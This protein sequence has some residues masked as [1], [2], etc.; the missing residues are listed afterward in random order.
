MMQMLRPKM[1]AVMM[2]KRSRFF[3]MMPEPAAALYIEE[4]I[5]SETPVPLPECMRMSRMVRIPEMN[6][7]ARRKT[8]RGPTEKL[9]V[10]RRCRYKG[11]E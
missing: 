8:L 10:L 4:A 6:M 1:T 11:I 5:M 9:L 3:S 2:V 7:R